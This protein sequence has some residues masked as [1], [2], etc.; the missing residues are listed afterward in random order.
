LSPGLLRELVPELRTPWLDP[1]SMRRLGKYV[2]G[3]GLVI[4]ATIGFLVPPR[5]PV[6]LVVP[7]L[8]LAAYNG[9]FSSSWIGSPTRRSP[10]WFG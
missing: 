1:D 8:W 2:T 3:L 10:G 9:L 4:V 6:L 5:A 7:L